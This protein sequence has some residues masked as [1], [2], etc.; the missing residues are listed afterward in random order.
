MRVELEAGQPV[1]LVR[2]APGM[3]DTTLCTGRVAPALDAAPLELTVEHRGGSVRVTAGSEL[4]SCSATL[5]RGGVGAE[6]LT[7]SMDLTQLGADR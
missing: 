1:L 7:G 3:V 5:G 2:H 6:A 4:L